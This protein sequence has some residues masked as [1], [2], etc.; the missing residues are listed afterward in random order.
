MTRIEIPFREDMAC[1][2]IAGGKHCTTRS[3]KYGE[4]GDQFFVRWKGITQ[5]MRLTH[6]ERQNLGYVATFLHDAEGC[7]S[8]TDFINLWNEIHPKVGFKPDEKKW[9]HWFAK[10]GMK[11]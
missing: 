7:Y 1:M 3:K 2:I 11:P 10:C 4:V 5:N 8:G 9:V 6:V